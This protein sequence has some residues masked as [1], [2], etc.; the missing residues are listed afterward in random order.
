[1]SS[2]SWLPVYKDLELLCH[3][4]DPSWP[5]PLLLRYVEI[6]SIDGRLTMLLVSEKEENEE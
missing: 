4:Q 5:P 6:V 2:N 3:I 1:M